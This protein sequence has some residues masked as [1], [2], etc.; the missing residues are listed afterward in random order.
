MRMLRNREVLLIFAA[1][2]LVAVLG[3]VAGLMVS[4]FAAGIVGA[5]SVI[6][7][8]A[9]LLFTRWRYRE[10]DRLSEYLAQIGRAS[11]RERV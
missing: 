5:V 1:M 9:F 3:V 7:I 10:V 4:L 8:L 2:V 6:L 11:W